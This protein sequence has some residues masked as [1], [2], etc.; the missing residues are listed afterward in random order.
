MKLE[1][2]KNIL[3][4]VGKQL[5][6]YENNESIISAIRK[7]KSKNSWFTDENITFALD[8]VINHYCNEEKLNQWL[9]KY[10]KLEKSIPKNVGLILAGN[11]P[12]VGIHDVITVFLSGHNTHIKYSEKDA[13]LI[14]M[15]I[16]LMNQ[17]DSNVEKLIMSV[18]RL[19]GMD[20]VV[21]TGSNNSARYFDY[22]FK[23]I[24]TIIRKNRNSVAIL[25]GSE[26]DEAIMG[27]AKDV[28]TYFGLGCRN[29]SK[30][31][32]PEGFD[33]TRLLSLFESYKYLVDHNKYK[34]NYDYNYAIYLLNKN[35][36]LAN[37][38]IIFLKD[39]ALTS[40]I[41][42]LHY[43]YYKDTDMLINHLSDIADEVQCYLSNVGLQ[44]IETLHLGT[45][46]YPELWDYADGID[47]FEFL[48]K[49]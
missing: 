28:F 31:Y 3:I 15:F 32:I 34:N 47:T 39:S 23:D 20:A 26:S 35:E 33:L 9:S 14:P 41:A 25:D 24:P 17:I 11:I 13:A 45:S 38:N 43:E 19:K 46:Q 48:N 29:V 7:A 30:I 44:S 16:N 22:Y 12:F 8:A 2:R 36:F 37:E 49:L 1:E 40:R 18:E 10:D 6:E 27:L 21:A 5:A 4:E 42:C